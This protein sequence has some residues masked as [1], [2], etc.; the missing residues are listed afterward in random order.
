MN[1]KR[2]TGIAHAKPLRL[3]IF[4]NIRRH[5]DIRVRVHIHMT[6]SGPCLNHGNCTVLHHIC[7]QPRAAP[8]DQ[9]IDHPMHF[10]HGIDCFPAR[11]FHKDNHILGK[12]FLSESRLNGAHNRLV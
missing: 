2:L 4:D 7:D 5:T 12:P 1:D 3:C 6:V 11:I 10:H 9:H 8:G